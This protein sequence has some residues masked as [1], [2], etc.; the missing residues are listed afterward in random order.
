M[1]K[2]RRRVGEDALRNRIHVRIARMVGNLHGPNRY[3][4]RIG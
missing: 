3:I 2:A 1:P 4:V